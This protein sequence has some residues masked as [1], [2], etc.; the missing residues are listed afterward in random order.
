M[1]AC[2]ETK[3][4]IG[5]LCLGLAAC[6]APEPR[7]PEPKA[8]SSATERAVRPNVVIF[9]VDTLRADAV[10][11]GGAT[12][13]TTPKLQAWAQGGAIFEQATTP[14][15]WTRPA[16]A[17]LF[18]GLYPAAHGVQDQAH[19]L[20]ASLVTLAEV[21]STNG[22]ATRAF[23]SN[24]AV[25]PQ[26]GT[27]HGFQTFRF[28]DRKRDV[29]MPIDP[30]I[31]YVPIFF[32]DPE[33]KAFFERPPAE[34]FFA[35]VHTTDPHQP[36][37]PPLEY[38]LWGRQNRD[39]YDGEVRFSDDF[40]AGWI[41][42]LRAS[43]K[44]NNTI[45]V[46]SSDHGEEFKEHAGEGHGH[47]VFEEIVRIPL[48]MVGPG[49][50]AA[51]HTEQVSLL[52]LGP[53][54]LQLAGLQQPAEFGTQGRSFASLLSGGGN[55]QEWDHSYHE[56]IYPTKGIAFAIRVKNWKLVSIAQDSYGRKQQTLLYDLSVD[57]GEQHD[58]S[59]KE[60]ARLAAMR[61]TMK[62]VRTRQLQTA[63]PSQTVPL[64]PEAEERLRT[65][66]YVK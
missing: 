44:L 25:A 43:G 14:A 47:T 28:F 61:E 17:S 10:T 11:W 39:R 38:L 35:Y 65:L 16:V 51:R 64:D 6:A 31:G 3:N 59:S 27:D 54:V 50:S 56:L 20:P 34:P 57:P 18:T 58:L 66:G 4:L 12:R 13:P 23:V 30:K 5:L 53:T 42:A 36:Y 8:T 15:G 29:T 52:D 37:R 32:M 7:A 19:V 45:V 26:F 33:V 41:D 46:F 24:F 62:Q 21:F 9:L 22:Y 55:P 49:I 2:T 48:V 60:P 63:T 1:S 40:I